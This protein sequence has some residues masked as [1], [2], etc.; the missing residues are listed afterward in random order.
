MIFF[1]W[2]R[3]IR[4]ICSFKKNAVLGKN[5]KF[6]IHGICTNKSGK[7]ENIKIGGNSL[8]KGSIYADESGK[9]EIGDHFYMGSHSLIGSAESIRIGRCVIISNDVLIYD[10]NNH[11][12]SPKMREKM[13]M[14]GFLN[15]NWAWKYADKA[16]V[17][18]EDNVWIGQYV[19]VLKGVTIGKGAVIATKAVVTKNVPH[20]SVAAGNPAKVV[21]TLN[22]EE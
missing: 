20:Y 5:I 7:I 13:S 1:N 2:L 6:G 3:H 21:K 9:I 19:T 11:P 12:T 15:E 14:N 8:I 18:I 17:V 22:A 16:P 4:S 10:N